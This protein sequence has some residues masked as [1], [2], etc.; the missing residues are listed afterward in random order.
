MDS[1]LYSVY[2]AHLLENIVSKGDLHA[3]EASHKEDVDRAA[4]EMLELL[5]ALARLVDKAEAEEKI[6]ED[7]LAS[8]LHREVW[9]NL[10]IH[11]IIPGSAYEKQI[12]GDL[13]TL[14][15]KSQALVTRDRAEYFE[16]DVELNTVLR[17]GMNPPNVTEQ[18][19]RLI[20]LLPR[21]EQEIRSLSY[22]KVVFL[23][24]VYFLET[25]RASLADCS[26]ILTYF[27]DPGL[28]KS[29][30]DSCLSAISEEV[31]LI[32]LKQV[33]ASERPVVRRISEQLATMFSG[34]CHRIPRVQQVATLCADRIINQIPSALCQRS[35]LFA[36]LELLSLLWT[37]CLEAELDEYG[38]RTNYISA[39]GKVSI[40]LSDDYDLRR[41]T[42]NSLHRRAKAWVTF[43]VNISPLDVKSLLQVS[44]SIPVRG[45]FTDQYRHTSRNMTMRGSMVM[46]LSAVVSRSTWAR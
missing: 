2:L 43:V 35:S 6:L 15:I 40:E 22:P 25:Y 7:E 29:S 10:V 11:G 20:K 41:V 46:C 32:Y 45:I 39:L 4:R 1:S 31:M 33:T 44:N 27:L 16:S 37:S 38:L 13:G 36:L 3:S 17:R 34:C 24:S 8:R 5:P 9:F 14:A 19:K 12:S 28:T 30:M 23:I 42:L 18:K 26:H 21:C